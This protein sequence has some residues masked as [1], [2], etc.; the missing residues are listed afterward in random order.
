MTKMKDVTSTPV[1]NQSNADY[2][3]FENLKNVFDSNTFKIIIKLLHLYN[4]V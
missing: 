1:K 2:L 4:E 3:F